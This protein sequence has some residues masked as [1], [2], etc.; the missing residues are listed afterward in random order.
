MG[1]LRLIGSFKLQVSFAEYR[2]F[3]RSLLQKRTI[4]LRSLLIVAT[5]Y[6]EIWCTRQW[7]NMI[8]KTMGT[9]GS[10]FTRSMRRHDAQD[11]EDI[12]FIHE[13]NGSWMT[14][15]THGSWFTRSMR[16]HDAQD[17]EDIWFVYDYDDT[18]FVNDYMRRHQE[19]EDLWFVIHEDYDMMHGS[20]MAM[21]THDSLMTIC[22][23]SRSMRRLDAT[24][25]EDTNSM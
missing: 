16:R 14:M 17:D 8:Q 13:P 23:D 9:H 6:E 24:D 7:G 10:W 2:L 3:Y 12:W 1:W 20:W 19:Y 5:P 4:I 11:D 15:G 22:D 21:T 25:Y 18:W